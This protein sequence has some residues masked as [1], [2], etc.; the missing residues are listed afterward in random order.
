MARLRS[1]R[2]TE[3]SEAGGSA[4]ARLGRSA[5]RA[6]R[7]SDGIGMDPRRSSSPA[8]K[9]PDTTIPMTAMASSPAMR[10]TALLMAEAMPARRVSTAPIT[11]VVRGATLTAMPSPSTVTAGKKVVQ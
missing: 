10:D 11:T 3:S 8:L 9:V 4:P 6:I 2:N 1:A 7:A 5:S